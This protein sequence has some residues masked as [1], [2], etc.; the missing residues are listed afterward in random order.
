M[1]VP[2]ILAFIVLGIAVVGAIVGLV[3]YFDRKRT[4]SLQELAVSLGLDFQPNGN[5]ELQG[6]LAAFQL[7]NQ[8]NSRKLR[9]LMVGETDEVS[10]A[11]FD[12]RYTT[13][14]GENHQTVNQTV[15]L[16]ESEALQIPSFTMRP[17]SFFHRL[18][19]VFGL[20]DIDFETHP[21]FSKMF[22]LKSDQEEQ[23]RE[24]FDSSVLS[25]FETKQGISVEAQPGRGRF[26]RVGPKEKVGRRSCLV[27]NGLSSLWRD[28]RSPAKKC[29]AVGHS[30]DR[31]LHES[32][33]HQST[34]HRINR[35]CGALVPRRYQM[36]SWSNSSTRSSN[37]SFTCVF[38]SGRRL[39]KPFSCSTGFRPAISSCSSR[40]KAAISAADFPDD[41][42][43]NNCERSIF[44]LLP[45]STEPAIAG[46]LCCGKM[47]AFSGQTRL[48]AGHPFR[49]LSGCSTRM[50]SIRSIP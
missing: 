7:F 21:E 47:I 14:S 12:Y 26:L 39:G 11:I 48:Q 15:A 2:V 13:S 41:G 1:N 28:D 36:S 4:E 5:P 50:E 30:T 27:G 22:L 43:P 46:V 19:E 32:S 44:R 37:S 40:S 38:L 25:F 34:R 9:N 45:S 29:L 10:L 33:L 49:Q 35:H 16:M 23:V 6:R 8:G 31:V 20:K 3:Y 17:E 24:Y 18:G 42:A